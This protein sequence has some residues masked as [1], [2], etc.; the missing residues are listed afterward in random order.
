MTTLEL[1]AYINK[2]IRLKS[3]KGDYLHRP[4][5]QQGVTTWNTG[6]GNEW[7]LQAGEDGKFE[8]KSWKGDCLHRPD[9]DQGV[10]TWHTGIGNQWTIEVLDGNTVALKSW[11][12]D[13]LHRPDQAQGVTTWHT[14]IG[15]QWT[16]E[17][18]EPVEAAAEEP[19]NT[20]ET[21]AIPVEPTIPVEPASANAGVIISQLIYKGEVKQK[22]SDEYVEI[23]NQGAAATD[24]SGWKITSAH[25]KRQVFTF[26]AGTTLSPGQR[27]RVYTNEVHPE[28][29]G[30]SFAS[31]QAIWNDHD[32]VATLFDAADQ[33]VSSLAYN[34]K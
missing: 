12:G 31:A 34:A 4:D 26:P 24:V 18:V 29:G 20:P 10:T 9:Q 2:K 23:T 1:T 13:Y 16:L 30:F 27:V 8:L 32:D 3:W 21:P 14:G 5:Q 15:N 6:I 22:Q 17:A 33:V 7:T 19:A 25:S 28:T 11:K